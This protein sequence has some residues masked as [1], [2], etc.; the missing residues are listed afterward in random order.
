MLQL[1]F[2]SLIILIITQL[3]CYYVHITPLLPCYQTFTLCLTWL[4]TWYYPTYAITL[5]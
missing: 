5:I 2:K 1:L 4:L 3:H